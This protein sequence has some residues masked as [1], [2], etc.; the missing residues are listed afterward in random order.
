MTNLIQTCINLGIITDNKPK[1]LIQC[2]L[3]DESNGNSLYLNFDTNCYKCYGKC[4]TSGKITELVRKL[5]IN[6]IEDNS[7]LLN[8]INKQREND[9][10]PVSP[11][12]EKDKKKLLYFYNQNK[13]IIPYLE[14]RKLSAYYVEK[15]F[16]YLNPYNNRIYI[17]IW[18]NNKYYGNVTRTIYNENVIIE[19]ICTEKQLENNKSNKKY[20]INEILK[21]DNPEFEQYRES[22]K[23]TRCFERYLNDYDLPKDRILYEP[24][25]NE[26][27]RQIT[28]LQEGSLDALFS[29]QFG[30]NALSVLGSGINENHAKYVMKKFKGKNLI[31]AFD[32]DLAGEKFYNQAVQLFKQLLPKI[33]YNLLDR[34]VKDIPDLTKKELDYLIENIK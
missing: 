32:N 30:Y 14:S 2:F 20:I 21:T 34:K 23:R 26:N 25:T 29:N 15:N 24:L 1:Q 17:P 22:C 4:Q 33:D 31:C 6:Y 27:G 16:L 5:G 28:L 3:H 7:F 19:R 18:F 9:N 11:L 10:K 12:I 8:L 13:G